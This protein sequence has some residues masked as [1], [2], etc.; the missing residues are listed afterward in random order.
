MEEWRDIEGYEGLFQISNEGRVKSLKRKITINRCNGAYIRTIEEKIIKP[1]K[2]G[3]GRLQVQLCKNGIREFPL[4]HRL[5]ANA[6]VPNP[7]NYDVVHH[8][9]H[10]PQNNKVENLMWMTKEEHDKLHRIEQ[11]AKTSRMVYQYTLN[12]ILVKIWN[13]TKE[14]GRNGFYQSA[15][16]ACCRGEYKQYKGFRWSYVPL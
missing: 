16:A 11:A 7:N 3:K 8:I 6:F 4:L 5:V 2:N 12:D 13:S 15:V 10:N 1:Y 9:D 14:C